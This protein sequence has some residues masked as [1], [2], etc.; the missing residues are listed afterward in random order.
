[1][2]ICQIGLR[3]SFNVYLIILI[4]MLRDFI[5]ITR[6]RRR[7]SYYVT[8]RW[9]YSKHRNT[10]CFTFRS[11]GDEKCY[12]LC[13]NLLIEQFCCC[14][15]VIHFCQSQGVLLTHWDR[16]KMAAIS[17][18]ILSNAFSWM[19]MLEFQ[20]KFHW[21]LFLRVQLTI[22]QHWFR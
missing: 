5:T 9:C 7:I 22:F 6:N 16:D 13:R 8:N 19:K 14:Q 2:H 1:M 3:F 17:Q 10:N 20:L 18:T 4:S 12:L 21:S 11:L 15:C